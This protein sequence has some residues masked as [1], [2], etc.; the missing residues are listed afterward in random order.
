MLGHW[1]LAPGKAP[2]DLQ[3]VSVLLSGPGTL[4]IPVPWGFHGHILAMWLQ[5]LLDFFRKMSFFRN[6]PRWAEADSRQQKEPIMHLSSQHA[7]WHHVGC[8]KLTMEGV[9]ILGKSANSINQGFFFLFFLS[10][11]YNT[12]LEISLQRKKEKKTHHRS[13]Q[14][15]QLESSPSHPP[16]HSRSSWC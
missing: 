10:T 9:F 3:T 14:P 11:T 12:T 16:H 6:I 8:L 1:A 13:Q 7:Q 4:S 5:I 15:V 2:A